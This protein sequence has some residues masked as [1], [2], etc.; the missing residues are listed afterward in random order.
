MF[1][2][3]AMLEIEVCKSLW[4]LSGKMGHVATCSDQISTCNQMVT[5]EIKEKF[6]ARFVQILIISRAFR[7]GK[8]LG[9]GQNASEIIP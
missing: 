1:L 5:S 4:E 8:L 7:R 2:E 3:G 6:H 9:F